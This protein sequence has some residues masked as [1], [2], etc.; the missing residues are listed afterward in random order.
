MAGEE[1]SA[2][3]LGRG[4]SWKALL[5]AAVAAAGSR[6]GASWVSSYVAG[7]RFSSGR[8]FA[9]RGDGGTKTL[10]CRHFPKKNG[11]LLAFGIEK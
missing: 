4:F 7:L 8:S 10:K 1:S 6:P 11:F 5:C 9:S 2:E 3:G